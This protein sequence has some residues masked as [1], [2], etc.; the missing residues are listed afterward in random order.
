[1]G[2][3][4]DDLKTAADLQKVITAAGGVIVGVGAA[5]GLGLALMPF[6]AA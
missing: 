3:T 2:S 4:A 5:V 6:L 1:M